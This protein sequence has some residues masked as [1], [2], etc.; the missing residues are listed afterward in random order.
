M[1]GP[2]VTVL[3]TETVV[4]GYYFRVTHSIAWAGLDFRHPV[5]EVPGFDGGRPRAV[6]QSVSST[7]EEATPVRNASQQ[8]D[9]CI[10]DVRRRCDCILSVG[11]KWGAAFRTG[12]A[13]RKGKA[14][15]NAKDGRLCGPNVLPPLP[16]VVGDSAG[17]AGSAFSPAQGTT[18]P[19]G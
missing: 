11:V 4:G 13:L 15:S 5:R 10:S 7:Q 19:R 8:L 1:I 2:R 12:F 16:R 3:Q 18:A 6:T 9:A 14:L 17:H